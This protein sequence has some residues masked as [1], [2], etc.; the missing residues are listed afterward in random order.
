MR[1]GFRLTMNAAELNT[2]V[3]IVG[4][5]AAAGLSAAA[6]KAGWYTV[7]FIVGGVAI[8]LG[9]GAVVHKLAYR[10][11]AAGLHDKRAWLGWSLLFAYTL[12]PLALCMCAILSTGLLTIWLV[13]HIL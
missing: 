9:S 7:P 2:L 12:L 3:A 10:L 8:G 6:E 5:P 11:L 1:C 13:R 4:C